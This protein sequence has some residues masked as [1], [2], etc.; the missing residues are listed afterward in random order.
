[1]R[2][3]LTDIMLLDVTRHL[4]C[5]RG[6]LVGFVDANDNHKIDAGQIETR[7]RHENIYVFRYRPCCTVRQ[8]HGFVNGAVLVLVVEDVQ[9]VGR[10]WV[11]IFKP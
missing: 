2:N 5:L 11:I 3:S 4:L 8:C 7:V 9:R 1:L 6:K 10:L